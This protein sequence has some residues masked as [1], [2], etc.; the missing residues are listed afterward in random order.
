MIISVKSI[1]PISLCLEDFRILA[2]DLEI[3][4]GKE[5]SHDERLIELHGSPEIMERHINVDGPGQYRVSDY[6]SFKDD[7]QAIRKT[8]RV[9]SE[10][11]TSEGLQRAVT[12]SD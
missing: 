8:V 6:I 2:S 11:Y 12:P 5:I 9:G 7:E 4:A 1:F 10:N 3:L